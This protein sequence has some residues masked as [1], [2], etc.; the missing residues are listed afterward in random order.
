M[1]ERSVRFCP[2]YPTDLIQFY[3]AKDSF[4]FSQK[5]FYA[6]QLDSKEDPFETTRDTQTK[7]FELEYC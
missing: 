6:L 4:E 5:D 3:S 1:V 2:K 7:K